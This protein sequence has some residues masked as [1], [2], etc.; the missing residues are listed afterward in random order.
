MI[1]VVRTAVR[2]SSATLV[3]IK[4]YRACVKGGGDQEQP[5]NWERIYVGRWKY[6]REE[7]AGRS[8]SQSGGTRDRRTRSPER[9]T[10]QSK[11]S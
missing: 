4:V 9:H 5:A 7:T 1:C 10:I 2:N 8:V 3:M 11:P 6:G